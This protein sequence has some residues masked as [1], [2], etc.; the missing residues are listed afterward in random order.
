MGEEGEWEKMDTYMYYGCTEGVPRVSD[1]AGI[2]PD[3]EK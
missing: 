2:Y 3:E 1:A